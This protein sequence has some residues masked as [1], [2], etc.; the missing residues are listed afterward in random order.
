MPSDDNKPYHFQ[1]E[2]NPDENVAGQT[3]GYVR[4]LGETPGAEAPEFARGSILRQ[5]LRMG[6]P[7]MIGFLALNVYDLANMFWVSHLGPQYVAAIA[8]FDGFFWVLTF[9]NEVAGLGSIAIISRRY[10]EGNL[11]EAATAI[12]ETFILKLILAVISG[13]L[14]MIY[15]RP[16]M[17]L[18]GA[19][20]EVIELGVQFGRVQ[21][22]GLPA[23][24]SSY[25]IFTSL[26]C[27]EAPKTA[28]WVMLFGTLLNAC[29]DPLFIYGIGPFPHLGIAGAAVASIISY[30]VTVSVGLYL[31][32]SGRVPVRLNASGGIPV[33][34]KSMA[35]MMKIGFPGGINAASFSLSRAVILPLVAIFGTEVIAAYGMGL[36]V[37][38]VGILLIVGLS[39]GISPLIGNLAGAGLIDRMWQAARQ[40]LLLTTAVMAGIAGLTFAFAPLIVSV[41]FNEPAVTSVAVTLLRIYSL[42]LAP[43]GIWI[44]VEAIF[45]GTGDTVPPMVLSLA[46]SWLL[47]IP[48]IFIFTR[49]LHYDQTAIWWI[50]VCY[51][52]AGALIGLV[53]LKR[54]S[55]VHKKV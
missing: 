30:A 22:W 8:L 55:W 19:K 6:L 47:E 43:I 38:Q 41:F 42:A 53:L 37:T 17:A 11:A 7:S 52:T 27:I 40:S 15:L 13:A 33:S 23:F 5:I 1:P 51:A 45:H 26:R 36:R 34:F 10:G 21:M 24:F 50:H 54:G 25:T 4:A 32:N 12:K 49:W 48:L 9:S 39:V 14:G 2:V 31:L 44:I 3:P 18:M 20:G 35:A 28:M 29:L 46:T 16:L